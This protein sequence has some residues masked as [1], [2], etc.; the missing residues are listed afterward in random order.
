MAVRQIR[1]PEHIAG[2]VQPAAGLIRLSP[3]GEE[4][5]VIYICSGV[6]PVNVGTIYIVRGGVEGSVGQIVNPVFL[7][8][9]CLVLP[10][11]RSD[12]FNLPQ[13]LCQRAHIG[14]QPRDQIFIRPEG[15]AADKIR[16]P[17]I[18]HKHAGIPF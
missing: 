12:I 4:A 17:V 7:M 15:G 9:T 10:V 3:V 2:V 13:R 11:R 14:I 1:S 5:S 18:I 16:F 6:A 8:N